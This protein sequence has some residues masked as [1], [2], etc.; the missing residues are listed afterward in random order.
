MTLYDNGK[1]RIN[2][3]DYDRIILTPLMPLFFAIAQRQN[4]DLEAVIIS[5]HVPA[6]IVKLRGLDG[7][8]L[9]RFRIL[10]G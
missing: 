4:K 10:S 7:R 3:T 5:F 1:I 2:N 9:G 8:A 6:L